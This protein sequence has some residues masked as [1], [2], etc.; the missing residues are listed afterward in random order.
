MKK[1]NFKLNFV[2]TFKMGNLW[3]ST[4]AKLNFFL[5]EPLCKWFFFDQIM[6]ASLLSWKLNP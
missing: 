3:S 4:F 5:T 1:I 2:E 6:S